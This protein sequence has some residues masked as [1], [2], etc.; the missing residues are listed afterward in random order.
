MNDNKQMFDG[1]W[2]CSSCN[3]AITQLPFQPSNTSNLLCRD[4]HSAGKG[5]GPKK[6]FQGS[7]NC[8]K[9]GGDI[10]ELPFEPKETGNLVCRSCFMNRDAA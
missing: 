2:S 9:C 8:S 4:C 5:S 10:S 3:A 1:N 7:W 6:M